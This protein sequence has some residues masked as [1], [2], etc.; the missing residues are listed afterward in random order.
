MKLHSM[1]LSLL[2]AAP[3]AAQAHA[4]LEKSIPADKSRTEKVESLELTFTEAVQ[5]TG[6]TLQRGSEAAKTLAVPKESAA[7]FTIPVAGLVPGDYVVRWTVATDD[8]HSSTGRFTFTVNPA[9]HAA[10]PH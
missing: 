1:L 7:G 8:S 6:L 2:L 3:L 10:H 9:A 4:H 5:L